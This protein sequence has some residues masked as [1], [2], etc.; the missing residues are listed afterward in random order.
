MPGSKLL[1]LGMV[2]PPLIGNPCN[3]HTKPYHKVDDHP[4]LYGNN[5]SL[6]LA[7]IKKKDNSSLNKKR[8]LETGDPE[9]LAP[10]PPCWGKQWVFSGL[11]QIQK[12]PH[13]KSR[14]DGECF[15]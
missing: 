3:G 15:T 7:H 9:A 8:F 10:S 4:I 6:D 14:V 13:L 2:I 5:G 1:I 12:R 11:V